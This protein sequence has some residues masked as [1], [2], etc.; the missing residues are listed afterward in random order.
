[1]KLPIGH[2][3]SEFIRNDDPLWLG[4]RSA[5]VAFVVMGQSDLPQFIGTGF[6]IGT[7]EEGFLLVLTA[8]HVIEGGAIRAQ[9]PNSLRVPSAPS[10]LFEPEEPAID[11]KNLR[12]LWMGINHADML[13]VRH[14]AYADNLDVALCVLEVQENLRNGIRSMAPAIALDTTIPAIGTPINIVT[15]SGFQSSEGISDQI[16]KRSWRFENR[17]VIRVGKVITNEKE[18]MGHKGPSFGINIPTGGGMSGGFAYVPKDGGT[19]AACGIIS[20]SPKEDNGQT[21]FRVSGH[22]S[23]VGVMGALALQVPVSSEAN[24]LLFD[25]VKSGKIQ[26]LT[27]NVE[28]LRIRTT[29]PRGA[30]AIYRRVE[31]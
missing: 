11:P 24:V 3:W 13:F 16:G 9:R 30:C 22:T 29:G 17:P 14:V 23:I 4:V 25:L 1:L 26:D 2:Q 31:K 7:S 8:K 28:N 12:A 21:D 10:I 27:G 20:A 18:S 5:L 6:V 19:I 15:L